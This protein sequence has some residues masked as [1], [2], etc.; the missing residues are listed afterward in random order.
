MRAPSGKVSIGTKLT[1]IGRD[2]ARR[3]SSFRAFDYPLPWN[4]ILIG[5]GTGD[6]IMP[7]TLNANEVD[8]RFGDVARELEDFGKGIWPRDLTR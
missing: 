8:L 3:S 7:G 1:G 4:E 2:A 6:K 5:E